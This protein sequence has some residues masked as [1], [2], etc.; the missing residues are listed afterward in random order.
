MLK[1]KAF[2][3]PRDVAGSAHAEQH[4]VDRRQE[5]QRALLQRLPAALQF[6]AERLPHFQA[7]FM[8]DGR[9]VG[10]QEKGQLLRQRLALPFP[11]A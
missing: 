4:D 5:I 2:R 1:G 7:A 8:G 9:T 3:D 10:I 6:V 11:E